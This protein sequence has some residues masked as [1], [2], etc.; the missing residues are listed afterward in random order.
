MRS[1]WF[2]LCFA[3]VTACGG[4]A[5]APSRALITTIQYQRVYPVTDAEN[6]GRMLINVDLPEHK[7]IPFCEPVQQSATS[8]VCNGLSW[9][10]S[11]GEEAAIF[12]N[13]PAVN[14]QVATTLF[15]NGTRISRI[16]VFSNGSEIGRFRLS[17][18]GGIE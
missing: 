15:V 1:R 11:S 9:E 13:D 6:A 8:F 17:S 2:L 16:E 5:T 12:V 10:L 14:R 3:S 7:A 18:S 4:Q